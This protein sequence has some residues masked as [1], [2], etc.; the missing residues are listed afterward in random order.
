S[1]AAKKESLSLEIKA[2][3]LGRLPRLKCGSQLMGLGNVLLTPRVPASWLEAPSFSTRLEQ[4]SGSKKVLKSGLSESYAVCGTQPPSTATPATK[5]TMKLG[6]RSWTVPILWL[7]S[8]AG[9]STYPFSPLSSP[10]H[11][12]LGIRKDKSG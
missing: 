7:P 6:G 5:S 2:G 8:W 12:T 9:E 4:K 3:P 10:S 1:S 11:A